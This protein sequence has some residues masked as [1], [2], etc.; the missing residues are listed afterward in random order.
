MNRLIAFVIGSAAHQS[1]G[2]NAT[3]AHGVSTDLS[4]I[5][6]AASWM[7]TVELAIIAAVGLG[8]WLRERK[9]AQRAQRIKIS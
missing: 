1:F 8:L 9:F 7:G 3:T 5:Y 4:Q 6:V 2:G